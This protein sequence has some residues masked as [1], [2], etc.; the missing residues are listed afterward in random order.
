MSNLLDHELGNTIPTRYLKWCRWVSVDKQNLYLTSIP[1]VY[2]PGRIQ[3]RH[4]MMES[5]STTGL[6]KPGVS[7]RKSDD[8]SCRD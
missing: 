4:A 1:G 2:E 3:T 8:N 5:Q 7:L 6:N